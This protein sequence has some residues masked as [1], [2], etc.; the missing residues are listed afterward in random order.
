MIKAYAALEAKGKLTAWEY[1]PGELGRHDVEIDVD[2]CGICH[3]DLSM[4]HNEWG[5]S[6]FPLV[7]GH[8]VVGRIAALGADVK[9][10][11]QGQVVGLGWHSD[12]CKVCSSCGSGDQNL[13]STA[14]G[15]IVG[16]HG[17]FAEKVRANA[18]AVIPLPKGMDTKNCR[19]TVLWWYN[20]V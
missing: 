4:L 18:S 6:S 12:Y 14:E 15:T 9:H 5:M 17:G 11:Q 13:C 7:A 20:R 3:S 8:E 2:Y 19:P 1:E 10:L 16:R